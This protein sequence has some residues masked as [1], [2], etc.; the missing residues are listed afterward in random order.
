NF[1]TTGHDH[2]DRIRQDSAMA[3]RRPVHIMAGEH[4]LA[5]GLKTRL[6]AVL[7]RDIDTVPDLAST[8]P[9]GILV[10]T[11]SHCSPD[12]CAGLAHAGIAVIVLAA[13]PSS[14]QERAYRGAGAIAYLEMSIDVGPLTHVLSSLG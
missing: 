3:P 2:G 10:T 12:E 9:R 5:E 4:A 11:T 13:L 6:T 8:T 7:A 14:F 1:R